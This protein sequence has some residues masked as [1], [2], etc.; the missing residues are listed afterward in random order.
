MASLS[1]MEL[2]SSTLSE[3]ENGTG[4]G[5]ST[6]KDKSKKDKVASFSPKEGK[7]IRDDLIKAIN[8]AV[9][10]MH[11]WKQTTDVKI[12]L[13]DLLERMKN[14][15][16]TEIG[17]VLAEYL[18]SLIANSNGSLVTKFKWTKDIIKISDINF[19]LVLELTE[20][21][22]ATLEETQVQEIS[23]IIENRHKEVR[24]SLLVLEKL[25]NNMTTNP[26]D[27]LEDMEKTKVDLEASKIK[28]VNSVEDAEKEATRLELEIKSVN[29]SQ[30]TEHF[31]AEIQKK[32]IVELELQFEA[33]KEQILL[34]TKQLDQKLEQNEK[35]LKLITDQ[36]DESKNYTE[37]ES[38][39]SAEIKVHQ[40]FINKKKIQRERL[41]KKIEIKKTMKFMSG[42]TKS[43]IKKIVIDTDWEDVKTEFLKSETE[44]EEEEN[45]YKFISAA[46]NR[47]VSDTPT[48]LQSVMTGTQSCLVG[49]LNTIAANT[50][51]NQDVMRQLNDNFKYLNTLVDPIVKKIGSI[52]LTYIGMKTESIEAKDALEMGI[53]GILKYINAV[54]SQEA[55]RFDQYHQNYD[56]MKEMPQQVELSVKNKDGTAFLSDASIKRRI[57]S[58]KTIL[59]RFVRGRSTNSNSEQTKREIKVVEN[60]MEVKVIRLVMSLILENKVD[61]S[62]I[63]TDVRK[64]HDRLRGL[65]INKHSIQPSPMVSLEYA[66]KLFK[67]VKERSTQANTRVWLG[68]TKGLNTVY[69]F[70][71]EVKQTKKEVNT[72][73]INKNEKK[74]QVNGVAKETVIQIQVEA[75]ETRRKEV[76]IRREVN[77]FEKEFLEQ[78]LSQTDSSGTNTT[79]DINDVKNIIS[80]LTN[81]LNK[82]SC[83]YCLNGTCNIHTE[84]KTKSKLPCFA[85]QKN[86]RCKFEDECI[87]AHVEQNEKGNK[88]PYRQRKNK[89]YIKNEV[90]KNDSNKDKR[91]T[92]ECK[93]GD[94]CKYTK[95][96][97]G[98]CPFMHS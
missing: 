98:H 93:F 95:E 20:N 56:M 70:D 2:L 29:D 97:G 33:S 92:Q 8:I 67:D 53:L 11:V 40:E 38:L 85:F 42:G 87:Y 76:V 91:A 68:A 86:G 50:K 78:V 61:G 15:T 22:V 43:N 26:F 58:N 55:R 31:T 57:E 89:T 88:K 49:K 21:E 64:E 60:V 12:H 69:Y 41:N 13:I 65:E 1:T 14:A 17:K 34:A 19:L 72:L 3:L 46:F 9:K 96:K 25:E 28:I 52:Y 90:R 32:Q 18:I 37:K 81:N 4:K 77:N 24:D 45:N 23:E 94:K 63:Q 48:L 27:T 71:K 36:I 84:N 35:E 73:K 7:L 30:L 66:L 16:K 62:A 51:I 74:T 79:I 59:D 10:G 47:Q 80:T 44:T 5:T 83:R 82:K 75:N 6:S 54:S 39:T